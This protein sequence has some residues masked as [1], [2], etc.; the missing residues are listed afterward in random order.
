M[1]LW[2]TPDDC[3]AVS[4][5]E[6]Q[7]ESLCEAVECLRNALVEILLNFEGANKY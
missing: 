2:N 3:T 7:K 6:Q 4:Q 5:V 1:E